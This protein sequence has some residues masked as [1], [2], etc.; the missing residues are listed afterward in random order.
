[1]K[2][3][4][5]VKITFKYLVKFKELV[6]ILGFLWLVFVSPLG[7]DIR[8]TYRSEP[9]RPPF[10]TIDALSE[11]PDSNN[12]SVWVD[13]LGTEKMAFVDI[14]NCKNDRIVDFELKILGVES[15]SGIAGRTTSSELDANLKDLLT[16]S[17]SQKGIMHFPNLTEIPPN[18]KLWIVIYGSFHETSFATPIRANASA[19]KI[20]IERA[21]EVSGFTL[22]IAE[23]TRTILI[24]IF[25]I[26]LLVGLRRVKNG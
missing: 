3:M 20:K 6:A 25:V 1:M 15:V 13:F 14:T 21:R 24:V 12:N 2:L 5:K 16:H 19:D 9:F 22:F 18:A 23:N 11:I 10:Q 7:P 26:A 4:E 8:I 17:I